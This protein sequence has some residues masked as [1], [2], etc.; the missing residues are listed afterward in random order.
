MTKRFNS[1]LFSKLNNK[2]KNLRHDDSG[3]FSMIY[4]IGGSVLLAGMGAALDYALL[5]ASAARAQSVADTTALAAAIH[6]RNNGIVPTSKAEGLFGDYTAK[7]LGYNFKNWV[8]DGGQGVNIN[9]SYDEVTKEAI[10]TASG[11]TRPLLM[12]LFGHTQLDFS[13]D[14]VVKFEEKEPLDPASV[15]LVLDN[16]GSME[17]DDKPLVNGVAP[18]DATVRMDGL[19]A[20]AKNFMVK[21]D[22]TVG[23]QV[24]GV[25]KLV[26]RTGMMAFD[27]A[28]IPARTVPMEWGT[29]WATGPMD[30]LE[31]M[32]PLQATNSAPPLKEALDWLTGSDPDDEPAIHLAENPNADP[33]KY[34]ILMTDG[35]NTIGNQVWVARAGTQ[36]WRAFI[37]SP[38]TTERK[39]VNQYV[40]D[41]NCAWEGGYPRA[42]YDYF[43]SWGYWVRYRNTRSRVVCDV[44]TPGTTTEEF[45]FQTERPTEP[46]NWEEGEY[47]IQSNIDTRKQCD[48]LHAEGVEVFT[49]GFALTPG[50]FETGKWANRNGGFT[51]YPPTTPRNGYDAY[52]Y[53]ESLKDTNIAKGLLQYCA[54]KDENFITADDTSALQAAFDRIGE[55]IVKEIIRIAS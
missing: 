38:D 16:S 44:T 19:I 50:Q 10:V 31:N 49:I 47:D 39:V 3:A 26:L 46:G 12:Q 5:S 24:E 45:R 11:R 25:D 4:A 9:V 15:V 42:T 17:F 2:I 52:T 48:A 35:K 36:Q 41:G 1:L 55:T 53:E 14:T 54:S 37:T 22:N 28:I 23:P 20:S 43:G 8:I 51:P 40:P 27:S 29:E 33:L 32:V 30:K 6:V 7:E 21:L 13:N 34:V 18:S